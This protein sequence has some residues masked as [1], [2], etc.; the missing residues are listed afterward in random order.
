MLLNSKDLRKLDG[1]GTQPGCINGQNIILREIEELKTKIRDKK[2]EI[3][4]F[5]EDFGDDVASHF[6]RNIDRMVASCAE[7]IFLERAHIQLD[8]FIANIIKELK[9]DY[10]GDGANNLI[11]NY[12]G[13]LYNHD[14][15]SF[16][17]LPTN[18]TLIGRGKKLP[19]GW[20]DRHKEPGKSAI[21]I[22]KTVKH[23]RDSGYQFTIDIVFYGGDSDYVEKLLYVEDVNPPQLVEITSKF[24][25]TVP[26]N[27]GRTD[28]EY[29][30]YMYVRDKIR[31]LADEFFTE[32]KK[33][34]LGNFRCSD[35]VWDAVIHHIHHDTDLKGVFI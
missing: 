18:Q 23:Y 22:L 26:R 10:I 4:V 3:N 21:G 25:S 5:E 11:S 32:E 28:Y 2:F 16:F 9:L 12:G 29:A 30:Q 17:W 19:T 20:F 7:L 31:K 27:D 6:K 33:A 13:S 15:S 14:Y 8:G 1:S 34:E 35:E 24:S